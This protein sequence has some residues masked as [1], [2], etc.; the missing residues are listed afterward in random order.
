MAVMAMIFVIVATIWQSK[1]VFVFAIGGIVLLLGAIR[2]QTNFRQNDLAEFYNQ[3]IS[4][5]A[6]IVAEPDVRSDKTYLTAGEIEIEGRKLQSKMLINTGRF[7]EYAYGQRL[8]FEGKFDEPK[9]YHDFSYKNYLSRFGIDAISYNPKLEVTGDNQASNIKFELLQFKNLFIR[10]LSE[11]FTE[12]HSSF[13]A[14]LLVGARK[15]IPPD[16]SE[17][18]NKTGTTHI[19]AISGFNIAIIATAIESILL[20]FFRRRVSFILA[21]LLIILFVILSGASSSAVRAGIMGILGM[22]AMNVGRVNNINNA[23][24]LTASVMIV[25]NPQILHFDIGFQLSFLALLGI[26]Y[27]GPLIYKYLSRLPEA[28]NRY[29]V[30]TISAYVTTLP[31]LIFNFG[32]ISVLAIPINLLIVPFIPLTMLFGFFAG[33]IAL[34]SSTIAAPFTALAWICLT[35]VLKIIMWASN[36]PFASVK[37]QL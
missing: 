20:R 27:L 3:K 23:L 25:L 36:L 17:A 19:V 1:P 28:L 35:Y 6:V 2:F 13:L 9:E 11:N 33:S 34:I 8:K 12:P 14:G 16:L 5:T 37:W 31:I 30:P 21:L 10:K 22:L 24:A 7:P 15:S 26:V 18:L 32:T 4:L 29:L